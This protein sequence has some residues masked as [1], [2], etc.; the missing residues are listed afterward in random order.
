MRASI[1]IS[2]TI[3]LLI[4][5]S[6]GAKECKLKKSKTAWKHQGGSFRKEG[7]GSLNWIEYDGEGKPG[8][9]FVEELREGDQVVIRNDERSIAILLRGDL[10]GIRN[11]GEHNFQ[12]LYQG[13]WMQVAD[14]T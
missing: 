5:M 9:T 4:T 7:G 8:S 6:A 3:L 14:C 12:Q 11:K 1:A 13:H 2:A 10:A